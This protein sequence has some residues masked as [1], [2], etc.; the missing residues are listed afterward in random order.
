MYIPPTLIPVLTVL[1]TV[2]V[3]MAPVSAKVQKWTFPN[4]NKYK[5][6][7]A[8]WRKTWGIAPDDGWTWPE[9]D[10]GN[11][12][13]ISDPAA[14]NRKTAPAS[15]LEVDYP[16]GSSNPSESPQ[17]G[18]GFYAHPIHF[19]EPP[20]TITF[21]YQVYFPKSF[22]W[23]KGGKL[24]GL[25]GGHRQCSGGV[26]ADD[27]FSTR[28]MWRR[29][30][31]GEIYAYIPEKLQPK[32]LCKEK[33]VICN[34]DYGYSLGRGAWTFPRG[35][36]VTVTQTIRM[37]SPGNANGAIFVKVNGKQVHAQGH[38]A[39][40]SKKTDRT[41]VGIMFDTFFGGNSR[42]WAP[43]KK[44]NTFFKGFSITATY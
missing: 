16:A 4:W 5:H 22:T 31:E 13:V 40:L 18:I 24:P 42:D 29:G 19:K 33:N 21:E 1:A 3:S 7:E 17:G 32:T 27:C 34:P 37:N 20:K 6:N 23:V 2:F 39:I 38:I 10:H 9:D 43:K 35:K 30:G 26:N 15:V 8:G 12:K 36:W 41:M 11:H 44:M 28:F 14:A 25:Y